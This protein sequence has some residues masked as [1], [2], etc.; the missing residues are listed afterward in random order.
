MPADEPQILSRSDFPGRLPPMTKYI[1]RG[2]PYGN[3]FRIGV[4]GTREEVIEA[5][6][7]EKK[8]DIEFIALVRR[9]LRGFNLCCHCRTGDRQRATRR[10][11]GDWLREVA[12]F[13]CHESVDKAEA[14]A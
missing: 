5:Y 2:T 9:E 12:N 10:C 6:I 8:D 14:A 3:R 4:D 11:H 1:G 13:S 7:A